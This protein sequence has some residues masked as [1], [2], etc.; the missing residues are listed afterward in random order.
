MAWWTVGLGVG[1]VVIGM[2]VLGTRWTGIET[3]PG[4]WRDAITLPQ[5]LVFW[6]AL[7]AGAAAGATRVPRWMPRL[8]TLVPLI[9]WIAWSLRHGTLGPIPLAIYGAPTVVAAMLGYAGADFAR[10]R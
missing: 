1:Y 9:V 5:W 2:L 7:A 3:A 6:V 10:R 8:L 4:Q